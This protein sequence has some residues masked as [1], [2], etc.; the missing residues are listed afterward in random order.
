MRAQQ[1]LALAGLI[2]AGNVAIA[3]KVEQ[4]DVPNRCWDACGPVV[5]VS[6]R[7]DNQH[8]NDRAELQCICDWEAAKTQ[9]PLCAACITQYGH[10][11]NDRDDD[12]HDDDD[13]DNEALDLVRSCRFT[14]TSY[15]AAAATTL[16]ATATGTTDPAAASATATASAGPTSSTGSTSSPSQTSTGSTGGAATASPSPGAAAGRTGPGVVSLV[17]VAGLMPLAWL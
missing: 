2:L 13:D 9:I 17:A 6:R 11:D 8:D 1:L 7:C 12:D 14:T 10:H 16:S 3:A 15:N 5:G 4:D